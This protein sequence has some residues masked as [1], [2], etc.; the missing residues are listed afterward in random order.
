MVL[1]PARCAAW[2][3]GR[4]G[5][6]TGERHDCLWRSLCYIPSW[7]I[8]SLTRPTVTIGERWNFNG[9]RKEGGP[10]ARN[11]QKVMMGPWVHGGNVAPETETVKFGPEAEIDHRLLNLRWFDYWLK[12]IDNGI[13]QEPAVS[14]YLMGAERWLK[15]DTWP[16]PGYQP[17]TYY[18]RQGQGRSAESLNNGRLL[19]EAPGTEDPDEYTH[20]PYDPVPTIGGHG[21]YGRMWAPGPQ[22][23]RPAEA[24]ML[25]FTTDVL[26]EDLEVVGEIK[27]RFFA[28]SSAVDTD[29]VLTLTDVY[30]NGYSAT[31]RQNAVRARYRLSEEKESLLD[32]GKV[33]EFTL[34][35][36]TVA[37][38][39][40]AG[41]RIRLSIASSSFPAYLPSPGTGGPSYLETRAVVA[42]NKIYHDSRYPSSIEV[43]V[44][45]GKPG[46]GQ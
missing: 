26:K 15:S 2:M 11:S 10:G 20:D 28:S 27:A 34:T 3:T 4:S 41:H 19:R 39:F 18:L 8:S 36:D 17:V 30:P 37:N 31:L 5:W 43:P 35:L 22:D 7:P 29:F 44:R 32:P 14:I 33:Y 24:R 25:T 6:P 38:V 12:G 9:I 46:G 21:G 23:Q 45:A 42:Q 1:R 40:K 16:L 13:M